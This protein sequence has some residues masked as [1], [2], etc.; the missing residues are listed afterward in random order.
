[1]KFSV[2]TLLLIHTTGCVWYFLATF[3]PEENWVIAFGIENE[4]IFVKYIFKSFC[5]ENLKCT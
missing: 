1:M 2:I 4:G 3:E 5:R